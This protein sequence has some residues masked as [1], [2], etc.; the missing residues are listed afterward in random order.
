MFALK[1]VYKYSTT[2]KNN[3]MDKIERRSFLK[4]AAVVSGVTLLQPES[5]FSYKANS[6]IR[7]GIIGCGER[8]TAVIS[9][10]SK[11]TNVNIIAMADLFKDQLE[12]KKNI[13]NKLNGAKGFAEIQG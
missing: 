12:N 1:K 5:V 7:M 13:Y 9:S 6:A 11:N 8:G 4:N 2:Y 10:I 3:E